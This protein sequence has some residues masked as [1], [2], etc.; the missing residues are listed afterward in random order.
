MGVKRLVRCQHPK[1]FYNLPISEAVTSTLCIRI[2]DYRYAEI[3]FGFSV[4]IELHGFSN[5][6]SY[7]FRLLSFLIF[8]GWTERD[9]PS[10][11]YSSDC[12]WENS[13]NN[14]EGKSVLVWWT[15]HFTNASV[16]ILSES[17]A[18][19]NLSVER[20]REHFLPT[21]SPHLSAAACKQVSAGREH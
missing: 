13:I 11:V 4:T 3:R 15:P 8:I 14:N 12:F 6:S 21:Y 17:K 7:R 2:R 9:F 18:D 10:S 1:V 19:F 20:F 16:L 5:W